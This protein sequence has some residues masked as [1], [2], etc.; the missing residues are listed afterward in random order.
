MN[1][2]ENYVYL[3]LT[4]YA[5]NKLGAILKPLEE[6]WLREIHYILSS[7]WIEHDQQLP[8]QAHITSG[9]MC[10]N[11]VAGISAVLYKPDEYNDGPAGKHFK[12]LLNNYYPWDLDCP[13][14]IN[15]EDAVN[16]LYKEIRNPLTHSLGIDTSKTKIVYLL[17]AIYK[18][19]DLNDRL[20]ETKQLP[21]GSPSIKKEG[22]KITF[23][24]ASFYW[25]IRK[26][27]ERMLANNADVDDIY[28]RLVSKYGTI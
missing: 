15:K 21:F 9:V 7:A 28:S 4:P 5:Q 3:N 12:E 13:D 6:K 11:T 24:P 17:P 14:G 19:Q 23:A 16:E 18:R 26:M 27:V 2:K 1:K 25:G 20:I 10:L 22:D 8:L